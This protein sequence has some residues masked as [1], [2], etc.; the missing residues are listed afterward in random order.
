MGAAK[1]VL[2]VALVLPLTAGC[3]AGV[4]ESPPEPRK[5]AAPPEPELPKTLGLPPQAYQP[6]EE[7]PGPP[8]P[9]DPRL[10]AFVA[11]HA[12]I[13][14]WMPVPLLQVD[15]KGRAL[16]VLWP[17]FGP[18]R[19]LTERPE[20]VGYVVDLEPAPRIVDGPFD[21]T[22][23]G[24]GEAAARL[25]TEDFEVRERGAGLQLLSVGAQLAAIPRVFL[26][27]IERGDLN[28]AVDQAVLL[29]R[30]HGPW[31]LGDTVSEPLLLAA[32]HGLVIEHLSTD[33]P[34]GDVSAARLFVRSPGTP[35]RV[36]EVPLRRVVARGLDGWIVAESASALPFALP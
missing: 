11:Q 20:A 8:P 12:S 18:D 31:N 1:Y 25:G 33:P 36:L 34:A 14:G 9:V 16:V 27:A 32:R 3:G 7:E 26:Q 30:L 28:T 4:S 23:L 10:L 35:P 21:A 24:P 13:E 17:A 15:A 5:P 29:S 2:L 19:R 22:D 6:G